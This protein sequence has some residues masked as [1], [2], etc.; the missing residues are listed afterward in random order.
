MTTDARV[1]RPR[2]LPGRIVAHHQAH[3]MAPRLESGGLELGVLH[4]RAPE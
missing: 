2:E 3:L 4:D 1:E